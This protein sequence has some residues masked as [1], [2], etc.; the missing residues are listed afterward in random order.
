[1][2]EPVILHN[3]TS[4]SNGEVVDQQTVEFRGSRFMFSDLEEDGTVDL[5]VKAPTMRYVRHNGWSILKGL[6]DI[7]LYY[8]PYPVVEIGCGNST[9]VLAEATEKA[10]V[11]FYSCDIKPEKA[12]I[13]HKRHAHMQGPSSEFMKVFD[14]DKIAIALID[15]D[16]AYE[17]AKAEFDY[18]FDKLVPGGVIFLHD[19][20]PAA[21]ILL[22]QSSCGDVYRLRQEL[23]HRTTE[24]DCFTWPYTA[25]WCGLTMVMKKD[26]ERPYWE[27]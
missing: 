16:H 26:P 15:G 8:R 12:K 7:I 23:E 6:V 27:Q 13:F 25:E 2:Q 11:T 19:T 22:E 1:M 4:T 20:Y 21:E 17:Q 24:M 18:F 5:T 9:Y 3:L 14:D 10:D